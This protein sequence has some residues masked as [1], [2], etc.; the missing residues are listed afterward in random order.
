MN[1]EFFKSIHNLSGHNHALDNFMVFITNNAIYIF[2][3]ALLILWIFGSKSM[4]RAVL[5]AG[6]TGVLALI[7]NVLIAHIYFEPRP[8]VTHDIQTLIPHAADSSFP[9]DHSTGAFTIAI[10]MWFRY[11]KIGI[12]LFILALLTGFSRIWAGLHYP[13]DVVGSLIVAIVVSYVIV[14]LSR[15][16]NPFV[17]WI[18]SLYKSIFNKMKQNK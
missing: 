17:N 2:A 1:Y 9:S 13:F 8:F 15:S 16:F 5:Y 6:G 18:I 3:L 14:K 10:A 7:V 4:K 11:K 12:P